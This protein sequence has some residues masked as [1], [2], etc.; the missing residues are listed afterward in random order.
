M[1][2]D[3]AIA[4]LDHGAVG[5]MVSNHGARNLDTIIPTAVALPRIVDAVASRAPIIVDGGIRRGTDIVR[6]LALGA[7]AVMIGRPYIWALASHGED[8]VAYVAEVLRAELA[9]A[10]AL[11]GVGSIKDLSTDILWD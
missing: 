11:V 3:D 2:A 10:M 8:G 1:R 5:V 6:A 9:M 4:A 7:D